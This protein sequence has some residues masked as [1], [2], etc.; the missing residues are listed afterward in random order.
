LLSELLGDFQGRQPFVRILQVRPRIGWPHEVAFPD[1][2][3]E[4]GSLLPNIAQDL[5]FRKVLVPQKQLARFWMLQKHFGSSLLSSL[6]GNQLLCAAN[7]TIKIDQS[8]QQG[9]G[10]L[11]R[12]LVGPRREGFEKLLGTCWKSQDCAVDPS[13]PKL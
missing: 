5:A 13:Q 3:Q 9:P 6:D 7:A 10:P 1:T 4:V 2:H 8:D 11:T 12:N